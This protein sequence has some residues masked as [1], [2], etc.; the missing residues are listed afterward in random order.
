MCCR[1]DL[2][3]FYHIAVRH[4]HLLSQRDVAVLDFTFGWSISLL[5][6]V[7]QTLVAKAYF[8]VGTTWGHSFWRC[9]FLW[10]V[11]WRLTIHVPFREGSCLIFYFSSF[12]WC[13]FCSHD[14]HLF[15]AFPSVHNTTKKNSW[16][17]SMTAKSTSRQRRKPLFQ[18]FLYI[19]FITLIKHW[20]RF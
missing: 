9:L 17:P 11:L 10:S 3:H 20:E 19:F 14:R 6:G 2:W 8:N 16:M 15:A 1:Y 12:S 7:R 18:L 5:W 4:P 13:R